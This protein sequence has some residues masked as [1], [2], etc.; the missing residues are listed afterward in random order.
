MG[1]VPGPGRKPGKTWL[2]A[3]LACATV[4]AGTM[5]TA[6]QRGGHSSPHPKVAVSALPTE[7]AP[8]PTLDPSG[9]WVLTWWDEFNGSGKVDKTKWTTVIGNGV[10]GWSHSALQYY[11]SDSTKMDGDGHLVMTASQTTPGTKLKCFNG[12]CQYV[13]GRL[14]T[15]IHFSQ[16]YGRFEARIKL[17][18]GRGVWPAFWLQSLKKPYA[19]LDIAEAR[20]HTPYAVQGRAHGAKPGV[21]GHPTNLS[22]PLS[23]EYHTYGIDWTPQAVSWWVDGRTYATMKRYKGWP[24]DHP[25]QIILT[26]Q[27]GGDWAGAPA[28]TTTF[29]KSMS[30][31]WI[32]VY[33][34]R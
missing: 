9:K 6:V 11:T 3:A 12:A 30:V 8:V 27:V 33:R 28:P 34:P 4:S 19:E 2:V 26:L 17:P 32:R 14:Q 18:T 29:P 16:V 15:S 1:E 23:A 25:E 5:Y 22:T 13:S 10:K 7:T 31:D 21:G 20:N 24:F